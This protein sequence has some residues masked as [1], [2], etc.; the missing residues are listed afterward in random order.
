MKQSDLR[1]IFNKPAPEAVD[2]LKSKGYAVTFDWTDMDAMAHAKSFTVAGAAELDLLKDIHGEL[3][4]AIEE[5]KS[6]SSFQRDIRPVLEKK[7]WLGPRIVERPDGT[8]KEVDLSLPRRLKTIYRTNMTTSRMAAHWA[9]LRENA[10]IM[11]YWRYSAVMDGA[12]RDAHAAL[13]GKVFKADDPFWD[14]YFPP[15]G[16]NCRCTVI[17]MTA[18]EVERRGLEVSKGEDWGKRFDP[19]CQPG[20]DHNPGLC[21]LKVNPDAY[22]DKL[23]PLAAGLS[24]KIDEVYFHKGTEKASAQIFKKLEKR[25][26]RKDAS[27]KKKTIISPEVKKLDVI[28]VKE[29]LDGVDE[30]LKEFPGLKNSLTVVTA[31]EMPPDIFMYTTGDGKLAFNSANFKRFLDGF[32]QIR[33]ERD[34]GYFHKNYSMKTVGRHE[35]GHLLESIIAKKRSGRNDTEWGNLWAS[36]RVA[37]DVVTNAASNLIKKIGGE[38]EAARQLLK[39]GETESL[40]DDKPRLFERLQEELRKEISGLAAGLPEEC[41]AEAVSDYLTNGEEAARLSREILTIV[42]RELK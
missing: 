31:E 40:I 41:F 4:A 3:V 2:Y 19:H 32:M 39:E 13:H 8:K 28:A 33:K 27:G 20:W 36:H 15:N 42:R 12:T 26:V 22:G 1:A 17:P 9:S 25:F 35:A 38:Y 37:E 30:V 21:R 11:P 18:R 24:K 14:K 29:V 7:G 5:G 34:A 10:D 16:W 23:K 6:W